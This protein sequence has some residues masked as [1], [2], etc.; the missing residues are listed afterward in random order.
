MNRKKIFM[1][2]GAA[3]IILF[4]GWFYIKQLALPDPVSEENTIA[5]QVENTKL[6]NSTEVKGKES[7]LSRLDSQGAVAVQ[8][9]LLP[10][11]SSLNELMFEIVMNTHSVDLLQYPLNEL[12]QISFGTAINTTGEFKWEHAN[13][14]S[15]HMVG[16]L[17]WTGT[18][19]ED[20]ISLELTGIDNI[21]SRTFIWEKSDLTKLT[22]TE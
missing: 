18:I 5:S 15:H 13:E 14:D 1:I 9:T 10:E 21:P 12:A 17:K 16:Y 4:I 22:K 20:S 11:K 7:D 3:A 2:A 19:P 8:A 6:N